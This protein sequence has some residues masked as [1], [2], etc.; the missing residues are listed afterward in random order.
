MKSSQALAQSVFA[1]LLALGKLHLL[2]GIKADDGDV[3]FF[4]VAPSVTAVTMEHT[5]AH[6]GEPTSTS[7]DV[8]LQGTHRVALECKFTEPETGTCSR[9]RLKIDSTDY[10][11]G[12]YTFSEQPPQPLRPE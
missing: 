5:V 8:F 6:L 10:C 12:T 1:N 2:A 3:A 9:P 11:N 4:E 7:V